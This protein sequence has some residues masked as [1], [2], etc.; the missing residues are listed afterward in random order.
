MSHSGCKFAEECERGGGEIQ[1][2]AAG[3]QSRSAAL[4]PQHIVSFS[5]MTSVNIWNCTYR[6]CLYGRNFYLILFYFTLFYLWLLDVSSTAVFERLCV[7]SLNFFDL[8]L[9]LLFI[10]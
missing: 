8:R 5:Y 3:K 9:I 10:F 6:L 2:L 4:S 1:G 7:L